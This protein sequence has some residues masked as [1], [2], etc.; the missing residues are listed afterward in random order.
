MNKSREDRKKRID[1]LIEDG[2][3]EEA[4]KE[5]FGEG[6]L[7]MLKDGRF[8]FYLIFFFFFMEF[9]STHRLGE[10]NSPIF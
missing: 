6:A 2:R 3:L 5:I 7:K 8:V 10:D 1:M 4:S 9:R